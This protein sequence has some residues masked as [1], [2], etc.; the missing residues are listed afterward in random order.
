MNFIKILNKLRLHLILL[1]LLPAL[2]GICLAHQGEEN[3]DCF[4]AKYFFHLDNISDH[5][6]VLLRST[7]DSCHTQ[8]LWAAFKGRDRLHKAIF[9]RSLARRGIIKSASLSDVFGHRGVS[10]YILRLVIHASN[11][12][13]GGLSSTHTCS[14]P[15]LC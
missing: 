1:L 2:G 13:K 7:F 14:L 10:S 3:R 11:V 15:M 6:D 12:P 4:F 5:Q 8:S 9:Q